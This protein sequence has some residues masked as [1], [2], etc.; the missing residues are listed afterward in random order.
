M[1]SNT[2]AFGEIEIEDEKIITLE[3]G[4]IG[5][6]DYKH[7]TLIF[8][9]ERGDKKSVIKWLQCMDDGD[10]AF[11]VMDPAL[12]KEDYVLN[13][14]DENLSTLGEFGNDDT[15]ILVTVTVPTVI[16]KMTANLKAP[17]IFNM[18]INKAVQVVVEDDY[19]IKIPVFE[20][21]KSKKEK[22]GE[23][24]MLALTRNKGEAIVIN[25]N[26]EIT[27]LEIRGDQIKIGFTAPKDVPIYR[28]EVYIQIQEENKAAI[29]VDSAELFKNLL[30]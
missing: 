6:P 15:F 27:I 20:L 13:I 16:E 8:N 17:I 23:L 14:N 22:A 7:F 11:P 3:H 29:S 28:K 18:K 30:G 4:M 26:I 1:K 24:D 9:E 2:R 10:I 25:N 21:L 12:V 5:F 19:Q